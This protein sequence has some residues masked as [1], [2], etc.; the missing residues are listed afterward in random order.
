MVQHYGHP[1]LVLGTVLFPPLQTSVF[2]S[3]IEKEGQ[4]FFLLLLALPGVR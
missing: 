3:F 2:F 1:F 4:R